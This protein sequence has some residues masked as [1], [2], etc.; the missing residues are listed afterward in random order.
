[1]PAGSPSTQPMTAFPSG[2]ATL[3]APQ[4]DDIL[5]CGSALALEH[6]NGPRLVRAFAA[7]QRRP[8]CPDSNLSRTV[9]VYNY[10]ANRHRGRAA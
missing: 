5:K 1:M 9:R 6:G 8:S 3:P 4:L 2:P 7:Y 10:L